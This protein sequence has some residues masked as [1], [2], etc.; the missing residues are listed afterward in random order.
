MATHSLVFLSGESPW[1][2]GGEDCSPWGCKESDTIEQG[3][4][5]HNRYTHAKKKRTPKHNT[6]DSHSVKS[7]ENKRGKNKKRPT[8]LKTT[9]NKMPIF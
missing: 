2:G 4:I 7:E 3:I 8:K 5:A 6:K 9:I 1:G